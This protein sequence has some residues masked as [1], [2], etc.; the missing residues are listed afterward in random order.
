MG[1][2]EAIFPLRNE[3][4]ELVAVS[5]PQIPHTPVN[6]HEVLLLVVLDLEV[7]ANGDSFHF[8]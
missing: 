5:P 1:L 2:L 3:V 6:D 7:F 8:L 4:L